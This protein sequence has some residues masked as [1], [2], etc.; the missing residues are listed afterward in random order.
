VYNHLKNVLRLSEKRLKKI[1]TINV[2]KTFFRWLRNHLKL[3]FRGLKDCLKL[4]NI[5]TY[6]FLQLIVVILHLRV[7]LD[8]A[9]DLCN[10]WCVSPK[11]QNSFSDKT[12]P[13][14]SFS[15]IV[16][17]LTNL[18]RAEIIWIFW[19]RMLSETPAISWPGVAPIE[20]PVCW[21]GHGCTR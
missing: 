21:L 11:T 3:S 1:W 13:K 5:Y 6:H 17:F 16:L 2:F 4:S 10:R 19:K 20:A 8:V 7:L 9:D 14:N 12:T 18:F 15:E